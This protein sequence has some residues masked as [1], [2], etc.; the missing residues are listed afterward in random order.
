MAESRFTAQ[1]AT[2]EDL[3]KSSTVGLVK[4]EDFRKRR[5]EVLDQQ[6][7]S[8]ASQKESTQSRKKK[9]RKAAAKPLLSFD[10]DGDRIDDN[11]KGSSPAESGVDTPADVQNPLAPL[12]RAGPKTSHVPAP[13]NMTK[14]ALAREAK[15]KEELRRE[16]IIVQEIVKATEVMIPFVFY[17]GSSKYGG[18]IRM[19]K[20]E[21]ISLFLERA[22]KMGIRSGQDNLDKKDN[23]RKGWARMSTDELMLVRGDMIIPHHFDLYHFIINKTEGYYGPLFNFSAEPTSTSPLRKSSSEEPSHQALLIR[24]NEE[25]APEPLSFPD[26]ELEGAND[27]PSLTKVVD[28]NWYTKHRHIYPA[29]AWKEFEDGKDYKKGPRTDAEGNPYFQL[30]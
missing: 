2:A 30:S 13:R 10:P 14:S 15:I 20:G 29:S 22:R 23:A 7:E 3:L 12:K 5:A 1:N 25:K 9:S 17:E 24:P 6:T 26:S 8:D 16:Y 4:L 21:Q 28:R 27:D 11:S 18:A 19:K